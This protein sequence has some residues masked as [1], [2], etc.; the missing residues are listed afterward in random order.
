MTL[1][2]IL[3]K[4]GGLASIESQNQNRSHIELRAALVLLFDLVGPY[5]KGLLGPIP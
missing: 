5:L 4:R 1:G 2:P 3:G